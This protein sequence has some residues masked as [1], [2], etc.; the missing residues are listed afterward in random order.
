MV[1][2]LCAFGEWWAGASSAIFFG[3]RELDDDY[4]LHA[5][6]AVGPVLRHAAMMSTGATNFL[7]AVAIT[8]WRY[9]H[10]TILILV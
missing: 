5:D 2:T 9:L 3:V 1:F 8:K 7:C 4:F 10:Y 6:R